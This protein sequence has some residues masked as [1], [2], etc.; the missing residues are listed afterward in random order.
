MVKKED[1]FTEENC[2]SYVSEDEYARLSPFIEAFDAVARTTY[3]SIYIIDYYKQNFLYVSNNP[4]YLCGMEAEQ[5]Q[6]IGY[7]FYLK[8]VPESEHRLL[9]EA[10]RSGFQ[11]AETVPSEQLNE[12]VIS[13]DFHICPPGKVPTLINH[14]ITPLKMAPDGKHVWLVLCV[15]SLSAASIAGNIEVTRLGDEA[16]WI[17]KNR[18]WI[19]KRYILTEREN[20]VMSLL[21]RGNTTKE[22]AEKLNRSEDTVKLYRKKIFAK[23]S[24]GDKAVA[25]LA[26][27]N[28][29]IV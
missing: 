4:F 18:Q 28:R 9:L 7:D 25:V 1:F 2:V 20:E 23:L 26:A 19:K 5:V 13:Y 6:A 8:F 15:A 3:K 10:N 21:V 17:Y 14:K 22:I 29:K 27:I 16:L 12:Y 24:V 11:F